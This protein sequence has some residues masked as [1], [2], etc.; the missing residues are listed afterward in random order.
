MRDRL[1]KI[2]LSSILLIA[3]FFL[4][5][6]R[7]DAVGLVGPDEP[8]YAEAAKE[9]LESHDFITPRLLGKSWFEKPILY[10]WCA[11]ASYSVLG[12]NETAAR[13]PSALAALLMV[14]AVLFGPRSVLTFEKRWLSAVLLATS[15]GII[16]FSR[17][18]STDML[19]TSTFSTSMI[20]FFATLHDERVHR[21]W[22]ALFLAFAALGLS[23]L[24]KGP[25]GVLLAASILILYFWMTDH[26]KLARRLHPLFGIIVMLMVAA[27]WYIA[28]TWKNGRVFFNTFFIQ[29]NLERFATNEFQHS[30]PVWFYI[31]VILIGTIPWTFYLIA[32]AARAK[33]YIQNR[34]WKTNRSLTFLLLWIAVPLAF[35]TAAQ[36]KLPGY[37]LPTLPPLSL[38]LGMTLARDGCSRQK[39][40]P[41]LQVAYLSEAVFLVAV[42]LWRQGMA[43]RFELPE[44]FLN[45]ALGLGLVIMLGV[46]ALGFFLRTT[47]KTVV[48]FHLVFIVVLV[49]VSTHLVLPR[50]DPALSA[51]PIA[52]AI[53]AHS[54][55]PQ[56]YTQEVNRSL[57][58]GLDFYLPQSPR[59]ID[60]LAVLSAI[61]PGVD[62]FLVDSKRLPIGEETAA[63]PH[64]TLILESSQCRVWNWSN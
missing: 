10:Y 15:L 16:G 55:S 22:P 64:A 50:L 19:L 61:A 45:E 41:A 2:T 63:R 47:L 24:A 35:F 58:Y 20:F 33:A 11:A 49:A 57:Q 37:I 36:S 54:R 21:S 9:M 30:Q 40:S 39:V 25:V 44:V 13:L 6:Y 59:P 38:M 14:L 52:Q 42:L 17:A 4:F 31:P 34:S 51:R 60:S 18:A 7:L 32:P 26:W 29:H 28:C 48:G 8:R 12:I 46:L 27:P 43:Q 53:L 3:S 1:S 62:V 5:F 23:L 56:V